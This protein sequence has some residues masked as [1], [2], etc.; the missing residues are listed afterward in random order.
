MEGGTP[1]GA[2][3]TSFFYLKIRQKVS[4][5]MDKNMYQ[6]IIHEKQQNTR[7]D[8]FIKKNYLEKQ[9]ETEIDKQICN[10]QAER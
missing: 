4:T 1:F 7:Y 6:N 8:F 2:K 5:L 3:E 10:C 9:I